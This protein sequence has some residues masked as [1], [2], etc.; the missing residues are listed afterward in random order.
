[1]ERTA[2]IAGHPTWTEERGEGDPVLL[3]HG[4]ISSTRDLGPLLDALATRFRVVA[5]DRRGHGRTADTDAPFSYQAMAGEAIGVLEEVVGGPAHLVGY[6]DG[7]ITALH[8]ALARPDLVRSMVLIGTNF[9]SDVL[10]PAMFELTPDNPMMAMIAQSYAEQSPNGAEHFPVMFEKSLAMWRTQPNLT[11]DDLAEV[12]ARTLVLAGD[13]EPM[14]LSH[15]VALFEGI[16]DARLAVIPGAS[17][18]VLYEQ[19]DLVH[20]LILEFLST[21]GSPQTF[22]PI[23]RA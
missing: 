11:A 18:I 6:S 16:P 10:L 14:P 4:G 5:F 19:P 1:M 9:R 22:W 20:R 15:T 2:D 13:D 17:H 12:K 23:R 7:G 21:E 8:A 3:L